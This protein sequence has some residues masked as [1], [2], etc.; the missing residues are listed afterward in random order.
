VADQYLGGGEF[1]TVG[2]PTLF[3]DDDDP[4]PPILRPGER[5]QLLA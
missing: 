2:V 1:P 3:G 4:D 5:P